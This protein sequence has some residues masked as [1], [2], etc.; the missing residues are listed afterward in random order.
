[1]LLLL[2]CGVVDAVGDNDRVFVC[3]LTLLCCCY[4]H[5]TGQLLSMRVTKLDLLGFE[6]RTAST[7]AVLAAR[8]AAASA[9]QEKHDDNGDDE[10]EQQ[11]HRESD[12][13]DAVDEVDTEMHPRAPDDHT[14]EADA[15]GDEIGGHVVAS[16]GSAAVAS[17]H[18]DDTS[19]ISQHDTTDNDNSASS[20]RIT[21]N[22]TVDDDDDD[23]EAVQWEEGYDEENDHEFWFNHVTGESSWEKPECFCTPEELEERRYENEMQESD[24]VGYGDDDGAVNSSKTSNSGS[25]RGRGPSWADTDSDDSDMDIAGLLS[26]A[27]IT[28]AGS[29]TLSLQERIQLTLNRQL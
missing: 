16:D 24:G 2:I 23:D 28:S 1:M 4:S 12:E 15:S 17:N 10:S 22:S 29:N 11:Q 7:K 26:S 13:D 25:D 14:V 21:D 18:G 8:A 6:W 27:N 3:C 9:A 19:S 5:A 20:G